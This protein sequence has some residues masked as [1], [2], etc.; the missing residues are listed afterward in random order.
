MRTAQKRVNSP[1]W[2]LALVLV[3]ALVG[4]AHPAAGATTA[5]SGPRLVWDQPGST[6]QLPNGWSLRTTSTPFIEV[7][8]ANNRLLGVLELGNYTLEAEL[9]R[10]ETRG[11][12]MRALRQ[13]AKRF[14]EV[15]ADDRTSEGS[16][17]RYEPGPTSRVRWGNE[18]AIRYRAEVKNSA[19]TVVERILGYQAVHRGQLWIL[20]VNG[21]GDGNNLDGEAQLSVEEHKILS[22]YLGDVLKAS[23]LP[24]EGT[25]I[26]SGMIAGTEGGLEGGRLW[27]I[28]NGQKQRI[29]QPR[30]M[31]VEEGRG[32]AKGL[33]TAQVALSGRST[34]SMFAVVPFDGPDARLHLIVGGTIHE[35]V[36]QQVKASVINSLPMLHTPV[37]DRLVVPTG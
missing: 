34:G 16:G 10:P 23:P 28:W 22:Q 5:G 25:A 30:G 27:L 11:A 2:I 35:V 33:R 32:Y 36:V 24:L 21:H 19:G 15:V 20:S 3:A 17:F 6:V 4:G 9:A 26:E 14:H 13:R 31:T 1:S 18:R 37:L 7:R 12:L 29:Y 8:D